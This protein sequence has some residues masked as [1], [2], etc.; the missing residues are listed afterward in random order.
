MIHL[1][2]ATLMAGCLV[3][4]AWSL[5][6]TIPFTVL[7]LALIQDPPRAVGLRG[8]ICTCDLADDLPEKPYSI[9][10]K[11]WSLGWSQRDP[12]PA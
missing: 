6:K 2:L 3:L 12:L 4:M 8:D 7:W 11:L 5:F 9:Y 1:I 10:P